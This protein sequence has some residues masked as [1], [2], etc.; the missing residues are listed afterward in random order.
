MGTPAEQVGLYRSSDE[1]D[2][3]G[4]GFVAHIK[5]HRSHA[6][7][8]H[9]LDLLINLE[10][11]GACGSDPNTGDGAGILV[12]MPDRF[13]RHVVKFPLPPAGAYG[14]G[15]VFLPTGDQARIEL[16]GLIERITREEGQTVLGWRPVPTNLKAIGITAAAAAPVFEQ[17]FIGNSSDP[18]TD[19]TR[20]ARKLYVIRKRIEHE[21]EQLE[22]S[23]EARKAFYI[24][25]LSAST[26]IYTHLQGHAD[27]VANRG[28]VPRFV[29]PGCRV[30]ARARTPAFLD[31]YV[32]VVA[33]CAP[34][35][36][37][38]T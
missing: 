23:A 5:G 30:G 37:R 16:R 27:G 6:I 24:V 20:F 34:L 7:V 9:A 1:H 19:S 26:L 25:S 21:V 14:A 17:V 33:A 35:P 18:V 22:S 36:A 12:Q 32:S 3:C 29:R 13:L 15:L 2:A 28:H 10:H 38:R 8:R 11:R 4:V 31:Q